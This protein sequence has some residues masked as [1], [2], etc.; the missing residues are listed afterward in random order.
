MRRLFIVVVRYRGGSLFRQF[1]ANIFDQ[2]W[3]PDDR[4]KQDCPQFC[5]VRRMSAT[6]VTRE[7]ER[8][9]SEVRSLRVFQTPAE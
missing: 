5:A 4:R 3:P 8:Q 6:P 9:T 2:F 1:S 7:P